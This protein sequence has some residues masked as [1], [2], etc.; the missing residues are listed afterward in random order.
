[1]LKPVE[2]LPEGRARLEAVYNVSLLIP[3]HT[4]VLNN[5]LEDVANPLFIAGAKPRFTLKSLPEWHAG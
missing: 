4:P 5:N 2:Q 3:Y 1:M